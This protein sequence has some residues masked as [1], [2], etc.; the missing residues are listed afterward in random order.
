MHIS[1]TLMHMICVQLGINCGKDS[2]DFNS[3]TVL[4]CSRIGCNKVTVKGFITRQSKDDPQYC[5][6]EHF[7]ISL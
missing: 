1:K 3:V 4:E 2:I 5:E 7:T 6:H